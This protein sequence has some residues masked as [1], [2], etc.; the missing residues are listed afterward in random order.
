MVSESLQRLLVQLGLARTMALE[1]ESCKASRD[2]AMQLIMS[3]SVFQEVGCSE[4]FL[5]FVVNHSEMIVYQDDA[6]IID[7]SKEPDDRCMY[8][9]LRGS[10]KLMLNGQ[11]VRRLFAG[12]VVGELLVFGMCNK[13]SASVLAHG[14]CQVLYIRERVMMQGLKEF[15]AERD[16]VVM[17]GFKT[18]LRN[19][20]YTEE[21]LRRMDWPTIKMMVVKE[22]VRK[23]P[24]FANTSYRFAEELSVSASEC[25]FLPGDHVVEYGAEGSSMFVVATGNIS[26]LDADGCV[27]STMGRGS[28]I[29][30]LAMFGVTQKRSATVQAD[31]LCCMWEVCS[32]AWLPILERLPKIEQEMAEVIN[33]SLENTIRDRI[34]SLPLFQEF[35]HGFTRELAFYCERQ[36]YF[37]GSLVFSEGSKAKGLHILNRGM[38]WLSRKKI[39]IGRF[40]CGSHFNVSAMFGTHQTHFCSLF[41]LQ[42]SQMLLIS[43]ASFVQVLAAFPD[44]RERVRQ[45]G[46][47]EQQAEED[48]RKSVERQLQKKN[49]KKKSSFRK[50]TFIPMS[51]R[52][53]LESVMRSWSG[54]T[55]ISRIWRANVQVSAVT[56]PPFANWRQ[57]QQRLRV[58][59]SPRLAGGVPSGVKSEPLTDH[60]HRH[61]FAGGASVASDTD[62]SVKEGGLVRL[63][64]MPPRI[65]RAEVSKWSG[66]APHMPCSD[67]GSCTAEPAD[68]AEGKAPKVALTRNELLELSYGTRMCKSNPHS[69]AHR[70]FP[71][72]QPAPPLSP[73]PPAAEGERGSSR[74][75]CRMAG[76]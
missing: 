47:L 32:K 56:L 55:T 46:R 13:R 10:A 27:N 3:H 34:V 22:A 14:R 37:D 18:S 67:D 38:C 19:D 57:Q 50:D 4:A 41:V 29:G 74:R 26:V 64:A 21:S 75:F 62:G 66:G 45:L 2:T 1:G 52:A 39:Q 36:V 70:R 61:G 11:V 23:S 58:W 65:E 7:D 42:T 8:V 44:Y 6:K 51:C 5:L 24:I 63:P 15:P 73:K 28:I 69:S 68:A 48:F 72:L 17:F 60:G 12:S 16:K 33:H 43:R 59:R 49:M 9:V 20:G 76:S 25:I 53:L 54:Q 31:S 71:P 30:E 40:S 35:T